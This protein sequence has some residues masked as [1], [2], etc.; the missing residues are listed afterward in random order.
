MCGGDGAGASCGGR[1]AGLSSSG[2]RNGYESEQVFQ[3]HIERSASCW[4]MVIGPSKEGA[5]VMLIRVWY[6]YARDRWGSGVCMKDRLVLGRHEQISI[7]SRWQLPAFETA[8]MC[9]LFVVHRFASRIPSVVRRAWPQAL[10][11]S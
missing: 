1:R 4:T 11:T 2:E 10:R 3:R 5:L 8:I 7:T 9:A 6:G